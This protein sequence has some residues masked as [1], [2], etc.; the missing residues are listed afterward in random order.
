MAA[1]SLFEHLDGLTLKKEPW[2][3]DPDFTKNYNQYMINRFIGMNDKFLG[4]IEELNMLKNISDEVHY[5]FLLTYLPKTKVYFK[6]IS[7]EKVA[8][9]NTLKILSDYF[10][11]PIS[12]AE[13]YLPMIPRDLIEELIRMYDDPE[14]KKSKKRN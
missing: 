4:L 12:E 6:Y 3:D 14:I 8:D 1:K 2:S 11:V 5:N 7:K 9:I 13:S 10:E